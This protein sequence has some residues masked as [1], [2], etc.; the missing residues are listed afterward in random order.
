MARVVVIPKEGVGTAT[1]FWYDTDFLG[2]N[3]K[4]IFQK[5]KKEKKK[6]SKKKKKKKVSVIPKEGRAR[7]R[8]PVLLLV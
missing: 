3:Q 6:N 1:F 4:K 2:K 8:A 5:K 7:Q